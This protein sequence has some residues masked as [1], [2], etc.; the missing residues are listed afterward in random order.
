[1]T[2]KCFFKGPESGIRFCGVV[3]IWIFLEYGWTTVVGLCAAVK[4]LSN[5][6]VNPSAGLIIHDWHKLDEWQI[7]QK[8]S[9]SMYSLHYKLVYLQNVTYSWPPFYK[10]FSL[11]NFQ[12]QVPYLFPWVNGHHLNIASWSWSPHKIFRIL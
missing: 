6:S 8:L 4:V 12:H 2:L 11:L 3:L 10:S 5:Q 9:I 7:S 1:M